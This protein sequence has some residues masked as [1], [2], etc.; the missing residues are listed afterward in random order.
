MS[1]CWLQT[2]VQTSRGRCEV[3]LGPDC[4]SASSLVKWEQQ[5][6]FYGVDMQSQLINTCKPSGKTLK[7][8]KVLNCQYGESHAFQACL[9][10][11]IYE[12]CLLITFKYYIH[13]IEYAQI[14]NHIYIFAQ[15][16]VFVDILNTYVEKQVIKQGRASFGCAALENNSSQQTKSQESDIVCRVNQPFKSKIYFLSLNGNFASIIILNLQH[17]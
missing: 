14:N 11:D 9:Y 8:L 12:R 7:V 3:N 15:I 1:C 6:L 5:C 2:L 16:N 17:Q 13:I 4:A 10:R